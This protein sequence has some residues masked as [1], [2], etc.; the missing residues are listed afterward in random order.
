MK[1]LSQTTNNKKII[2]GCSPLQNA[3]SDELDIKYLA[4]KWLNTLFAPVVALK[5]TVVLMFTAT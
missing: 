1:T 4:I 2:V 3:A 5:K